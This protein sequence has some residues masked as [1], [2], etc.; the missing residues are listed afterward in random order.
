LGIEKSPAAFRTISEAGK[1]LSL[2]THVLRFWESKFPQIK[3][4]KRGGGR[5]F[6]RPNDVLVLFAIKKLLHGNGMTIAGVK[7]LIKE[8]GIKQMMALGEK[9]KNEP[10]EKEEKHEE[11]YIDKIL[12]LLDKEQD[13]SIF[14]DREKLTEI[15]D[16]LLSLRIKI[17]ER[18]DNSYDSFPN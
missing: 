4:V 12:T 7:R 9:A 14:F 11:K 6:Y 10:K 8:T 3:P 13:N 18:I 5:R 15:K 1:M 2:P 17:R 16:D